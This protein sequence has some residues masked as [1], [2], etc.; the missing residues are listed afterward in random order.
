M[1]KKSVDFGL[2][3]KGFFT[4]RVDARGGGIVVEHYKNVYKTVNGRRTVVSGRINKEFKGDDAQK[5]YRHILAFNLVSRQ[6]HAAYLG[7]ELAKAE[8][9][10]KNKLEYEQDEPLEA[11]G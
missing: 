1:K 6:D 11:V 7:Y 10:L 3:P 8:I 9:A 2:D 5:L 4:V